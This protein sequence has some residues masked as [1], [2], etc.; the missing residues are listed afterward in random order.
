VVDLCSKFGRF[1][2][3]HTPSIAQ[4]SHRSHIAHLKYR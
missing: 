3:V 1:E 2:A 4:H